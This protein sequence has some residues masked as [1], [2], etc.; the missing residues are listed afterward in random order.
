GVLHDVHLGD[1]HLVG[2]FLA[3]FLERGADH[4]ARSA[5]FRPEIDED[6]LVAFEHIGGEAGVGDGFGGHLENSCC[7]RVNLGT[8]GPSAMRGA[9]KLYSGA[10]KAGLCRS[11]RSAGSAISS[12]AA[13]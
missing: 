4:L 3:D 5:P 10:A 9:K 2:Q 7:S 13:V 8:G 11:S 1:G 12:G 6:G